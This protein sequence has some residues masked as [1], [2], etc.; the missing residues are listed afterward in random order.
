MRPITIEMKKKIAL[1]Q[2]GRVYQSDLESNEAIKN[3]TNEFLITE[4]NNGRL[5]TDGKCDRLQ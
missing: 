5:I 1:L 2:S 3:H 4:L